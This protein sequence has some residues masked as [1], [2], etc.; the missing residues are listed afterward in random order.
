MLRVHTVKNVLSML[1][2]PVLQKYQNVLF[3]SAQYYFRPD[4][5]ATYN[6]NFSL[7]IIFGFGLQER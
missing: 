1:I 4:N 7:K 6:H 3:E 5:E 2:I